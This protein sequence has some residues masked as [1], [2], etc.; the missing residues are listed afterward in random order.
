MPVLNGIV[1]PRSVGA[2]DLYRVIVPQSLPFSRTRQQSTPLGDW[3]ALSRAVF[4]FPDAHEVRIAAIESCG[5]LDWENL[6]G[7]SRDMFLVSTEGSSRGR[8]VVY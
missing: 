2:A 5:P 1:A 4:P 6:T 3:T 7:M 8:L